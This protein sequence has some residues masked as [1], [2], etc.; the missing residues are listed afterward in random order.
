MQQT[1]N[2]SIVHVPA[3][4]PGKRLLER[5]T[6]GQSDAKPPFRPKMGVQPPATY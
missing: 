5:S 1:D 6:L 4:G 2:T 3:Q